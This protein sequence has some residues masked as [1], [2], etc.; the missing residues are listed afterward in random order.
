MMKYIMNKANYMQIRGCISKLLIVSLLASITIGCVPSP[1]SNVPYSK[2]MTDLEAQQLKNKLGH[3]AV[4]VTPDVPTV[5][6]KVPA[7][8]TAEGAKEG[9]LVSLQVVS[10]LLRGCPPQGVEFCLVIMA[11]GIA[12]TPV[13]AVIGGVEGATLAD[14][15][16][17]V[18]KSETTIKKSLAELRLSEHIRDRFISRLSDLQ[19]FPTTTLPTLDVLEEGQERDYHPMKVDGI[20]TVCEISAQKLALTGL[21]VVRP[22]L[23]VYIDAQVRLISTDNSSVIFSSNYWC[24][25]EDHRF[26]EWASLEAGK[27]HEEITKCYDLIAEN[28]VTDM[29]INNA[30]AAPRIIKKK[31]DRKNQETIRKEQRP[32]T[33]M[34]SESV[35]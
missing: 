29:F 19:S 33:E 18:S 20:D 15:A 35:I 24:Y 25:T 5:Y 14:K 10:E 26:E 21:G 12:L 22:D 28:A 13:G 32:V 31:S 27:F 17:T 3:I 6:V 16:D 4:V 9:A 2:L 8:D 7:K 30:V 11:A 34:E 23:S 1:Y